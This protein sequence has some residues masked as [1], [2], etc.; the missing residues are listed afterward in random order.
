MPKRHFDPPTL[1]WRDLP[2]I[3][4]NI[5]FLLIADAAVAAFF[6]RAFIRE[7]TFLQVYAWYSLVVASGLYFYHLILRPVRGMP[8]L[9]RRRKCD[10]F[11]TWISGDGL[12]ISRLRER[13]STDELILLFGF[14]VVLLLAMLLYASRM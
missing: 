14:Q 5:A 12:K 7:H 9:F 11:E 1:G 8:P 6:Q 4:V 2:T 10:D 3:A 13:Y